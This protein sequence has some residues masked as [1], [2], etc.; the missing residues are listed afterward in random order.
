MN[1]YYIQDLHTTNGDLVMFWKP[2]GYGKTYKLS[3]A[4]LFSSEYIGQLQENDQ[5]E[6]LVA[7]SKDYVEKVK[8]SVVCLDALRR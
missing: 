1:N 3:E 7:V 2:N 5:N 8:E 6:H 4:G